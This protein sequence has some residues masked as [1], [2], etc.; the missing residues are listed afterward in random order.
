MRIERVELDGFGR[1]HDAAW[2]LDPG[3]TVVLGANEAGKTTFLN[4]IRALLFGF[5]ATREGRTWYPAA[6]GGRRGGR[7]VLS[8]R[9]DERWVVERHGERGGAGAL[10]VRAPNGNQGGQETLDRLLHGAD[11]DLFSNIFAFGLGELQDLHTLSTS[12][13]RGRIYGA[14]AGLGG[15]SAVDLERALRTEL[16]DRF[17]PSGS[18]PPLNALLARIESLRAEIA[19]LATQPEEYEAAHRECAALE[20]RT[21]ALRGTARSLRE[22]VARLTNLR[23][24]APSLAE[25]AEIEAELAAGDQTLDELPP[26]MAAAIDRRVMLLEEAARAL[27][28]LDEELAVAR[29]ER[30]GIIVDRGALDAADDINSVRDVVVGRSGRADRRADLARGI[31]R[32]QA[33]VEEQQAR[34]GGWDEMRVLALDDSIPAIQATR[35]AEERLS[36]AAAAVATTTARWTAASG[37]L[38]SRVREAAA[39][40]VPTDL[41]GRRDALRELLTR[42]EAGPDRRVHDI[43]IR[44]IILGIAIALGMAAIG[45]AIGQAVAGLLLGLAVGGLAAS[46]RAA[47]GRP[48]TPP[49]ARDERRARLIER[50]GLPPTATDLD[51]VVL[52]EELAAAAARSAVARDRAASL[53]ERRTELARLR[54]DADDSAS[55]RQ[56]A[57]GEWSSWLQVHGLPAGVSAAAVRE[58][59]AAAGTARAAAAERDRLRGMLTEVDEADAELAARVNDLLARLGAPAS[60]DPERRA[61]AVA[62]LADRLSAAREAERRIGELDAVISRLEERRRPL[63]EASHARSSE[64]ADLLA[65]HGAATVDALRSRDAAAAARRV[66]LARARELRSHLAGIAGSPVAVEGLAAD[67]RSTDGVG[68]DAELADAQAELERI[69]GEQAE[70]HARIGALMARIEQLEAT[71]EIG[72]KRQELA[73]AEGSAAALARDWAVRAVALRLLEETRHRYERERQPD[74]VRA[75]ESHFSR[76]TGGRYSRIIAP[77]GD[78]SVRVETEGGEARVTDELSR[79]TAEQLYLALR[80]GLIEEFARHAEPLPVV[81]DD[82]LVNF[83]AERAARA[84][85]GIR[86]LAERHQ[87]LYFTCHAWTAEL[88]DPDGGRTLALA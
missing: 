78:S 33:T 3:M 69:D 22:R 30:A 39:D 18:K 72:A 46:L 10:T 44:A 63:A 26:D 60:D 24:A 14:G 48:Q 47:T 62:A 76:I 9:D 85:A 55:T 36:A 42:S 49:V 28:S 83:D 32:Q 43:P 53:E 52:G 59:L 80:F 6:A 61:V 51:L 23:T 65:T 64:L 58:M 17:V 7:L 79:G 86:G 75:A 41:S 70:A 77:P 50:A 84:A 4:A 82:I 45:T 13:V 11:R 66:L 74:V 16:R 20:A 88:L 68:V 29:H 54:R 25:L 35:D 34:V 19:A 87:V 1:F 67:A 57:E 71:E 37:E 40:A 8:T 31:E 21:E 15:S 5:D 38:E 2:S 81:M 73:I 56:R 12:G 27:A